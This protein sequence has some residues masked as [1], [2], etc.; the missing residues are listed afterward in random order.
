MWWLDDNLYRGNS[1]DRRRM[2][3]RTSLSFPTDTPPASAPHGKTAIELTEAQKAANKALLEFES[4]HESQIKILLADISSLERAVREQSAKRAEL[5]TKVEQLV[6]THAR[7]LT[8]SINNSQLTLESQNSEHDDKL[9][10]LRECLAA[11]EELVVQRDTLVTACTGDANQLR[12]RLATAEATIVSRDSELAEL[13]LRL[14]ACEQQHVA[15]LNEAEHEHAAESKHLQAIASLAECRASERK[16]LI[17]TLESELASQQETHAAE[18]DQLR[19][20]L[21]SKR[22]STN[23][24]LSEAHDHLQIQAGVI[25]ELKTQVELL[26]SENKAQRNQLEAAADAK[27]AARQVFNQSAQQHSIELLNLNS[28]ISRLQVDLDRALTEKSSLQE[29]AKQNE[30]EQS[31]AIAELKHQLAAATA[32]SHRSSQSRT[33]LRQQGVTLQKTID[34]L[35]QA[36]VECKSKHESEIAKLRA[37]IERTQNAAVDQA[38]RAQQIECVLR[39]QSHNLGR[40]VERLT[41][42]ASQSRTQH[43]YELG[44][45]QQ[46]IKKRRNEIELL[47]AEAERAT[48]ELDRKEGA[49]QRAGSKNERLLEIQDSQFSTLKSRIDSLLV[50]LDLETDKRKTAEAEARRLGETRSQRIAFLG[51]QREQLLTQTSQL[52]SE[53]QRLH[54]AVGW[55]RTV[56]ET[57]KRWLEDAANGL[58]AET[59]QI[60][61]L[62]D[63]LDAVTKAESEK[64][65]HRLEEHAASTWEL[66]RLNQTKIERHSCREQLA[67]QPSEGSPE[68]TALA[69]VQRDQTIA[70]LE[71]EALLMQEQL[72]R[73][74]AARRKAEGAIKRKAKA[75]NSDAALQDAWSHIDA[76]EQVSRLKRQITALEDIGLMER[77]RAAAEISRHKKH[78]QRLQQQFGNRAA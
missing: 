33:E 57:T 22:L 14:E 75:E 31:A 60:R 36:A 52:R 78:I 28:Q 56:S 18:L 58:L 70:S 66:V 39:A 38:R 73:E 62:R 27:A 51:Q 54:A 29:T 41:S 68:E 63:Q 3:F 20:S 67:Q 69:I 25:A 46:T 43:Q 74:A 76:Y 15:R 64:V 2:L 53:N 50:A 42:E 12:K 4:D 19:E 7:Q 61:Q 44:K 1:G 77:Q 13:Q 9:Q 40:S 71:Q 26:K 65:Q 30:S 59:G 6:T 45:L 34:R 49:L 8:E 37:T 17:A 48:K 21:E 5:E 11:A 16:G 10:Q 47:A 35:T 32:D 23:A 24:S 55:L 72:Q